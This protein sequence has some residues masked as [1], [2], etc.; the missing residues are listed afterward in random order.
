VQGGRYRPERDATP[1]VTFCIG[2]HLE[3]AR[4]RLDQL[5]AASARWSLLEELVEGRGWPD[6]LVIALEQSLFD[7]V[8]RSAYAAA[9]DISLATATTD[10]R[11]LLDAGLVVQHG[12]ARST[13][14]VA[15][16]EL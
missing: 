12:R 14:Y 7:G 6:R 11:R 10:L 2:A 3:R 5:A 4:M 9:A 8:D 1:W 16:D 15:S 13:R